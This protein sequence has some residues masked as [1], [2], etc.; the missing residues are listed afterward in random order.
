MLYLIVDANGAQMARH[1]S[2]YEKSIA[3]RIV[4][5][6]WAA[7]YEVYMRPDNQASTREGESATT[8]E[9]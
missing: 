8:R 3:E 7:G 5:A 6:E 4:R 2:V 9:P 1:Q